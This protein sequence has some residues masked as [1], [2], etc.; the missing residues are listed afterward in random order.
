MR[1]I[2]IH[3]A[4]VAVLFS[5]PASAQPAPE[6]DWS[7][8]GQLTWQL[9]GHGAFDS[10]YEGPNSFQNRN[11]TRGSFTSTLF[12]GRRLWTGGEAYVN[13]ELIAGQGLSRVLGLAAPPN[14]ETYRVDSTEL[15][16]NL[17]RLFL[18][19]TFELGGEEE[20]RNDEENQL[21]GRGA[22]RRIVVT[23]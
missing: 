15:K 16:A 21:Q 3:G 13:V 17:A 22:A 2:L 8:H 1:L 7:L 10:P 11:E 19:Q 20:A 9:Q 18:R 6:R 12:L 5:A 23:V 4:L 14:G